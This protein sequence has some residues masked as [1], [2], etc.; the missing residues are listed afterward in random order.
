M[1]K[2]PQPRDVTVRC[3]ECGHVAARASLSVAADGWRFVYSAIAAGNGT[4]DNISEARARQ[5]DTAF[6]EPLEY[7]R[8]HE[9]ALYDDA[10]FCEPCRVAYSP[11]TGMSHLPGPADVREATSSR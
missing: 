11:R 6:A 9:A 1:T 10:G 2:A 3:A 8:V 4:G 5:I 7:A